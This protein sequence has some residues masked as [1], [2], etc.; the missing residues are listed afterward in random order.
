MKLAT[1]KM[2]REEAIA[3]LEKMIKSLRW[4]VNY[5]AYMG[6][7]DAAFDAEYENDADHM[8]AN[9]LEKILEALR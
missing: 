2:T 8:R 7:S 4:T 1:H 3:E 6:D 5:A 9:K